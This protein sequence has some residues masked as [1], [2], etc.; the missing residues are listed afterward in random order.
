MIA[1]KRVLYKDILDLKSKYSKNQKENYKFYKIIGTNTIYEFKNNGDELIIKEYETIF[2]EKIKQD[3]EFEYYTSPGKLFCTSRYH[4][5]LL[6]RTN[7][8]A[9]IYESTYKSVYY[10]HG[11]LISE[12]FYK[13]IMKNLKNGRIGNILERYKIYDLKLIRDI[14]EE[15]GTEKDLEKIDRQILISK[16]ENR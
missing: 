1:V 2:E 13:K 8:P 5:G 3:E 15:Q 14:A 11:K 4:D 9:I 16:L 12:R 10:I 7:G 6:H